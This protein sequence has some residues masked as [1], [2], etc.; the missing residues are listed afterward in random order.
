MKL[1]YIAG[2]YRADTPSGIADNIY[3]AEMCGVRAIVKG[4]YPVIPQKNTGGFE[5]YQTLLH[6]NDAFFLD[7][8]MELMRRCDAVCFMDGYQTSLG[9]LAEL[10]EAE[11]L[12]LLIMDEHDMISVHEIR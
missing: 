3:R 2:P 1:L 11:R 5:R 6:V 8:T 9:S 4:W 12:G 10:A 7:G